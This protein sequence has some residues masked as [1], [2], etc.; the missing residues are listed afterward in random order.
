[1]NAG[2][3]GVTAAAG[4]VSGSGPGPGNLR[5]A[6]N[7][8][9]AEPGIPPGDPTPGDPALGDP[10]LGDPALA[11]ENPRDASLPV[12]RASSVVSPSSS[13]H[14]APLPSTR[15]PNQSARVSVAARA[16]SRGGTP[17]TPTTPAGPDS[18]R[19]AAI[20]AVAIHPK[21][22][23]AP[24]GA[25]IARI[26]AGARLDRDA[27]RHASLIAPGARRAAASRS[28]DANPPSGCAFDAATP[29][30][31]RRVNGVRSRPAVAATASAA[32]SNAA[33]ASPTTAAAR[34]RASPPPRVRVNPRRGRTPPRVDEIGP[35]GGVPRGA[36]RLHGD[37]RAVCPRG[38]ARALGGGYVRRASRD[39]R[40]EAR[41]AQ[42]VGQTT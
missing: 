18:N 23:S 37:A 38:R 36:R 35:R 21:C 24:S 17:T 32:A 39:V 15:R 20:A 11:P 5:D 2:G 1:M 29:R 34:A 28:I 14:P 9:P 7:V 40:R 10:A 6:S 31:H 3:T 26:G 33:R 12:L 30:S 16:T 41:E 22:A 27:S 4:T 8:N 13:A 42:I 25:R 19:S